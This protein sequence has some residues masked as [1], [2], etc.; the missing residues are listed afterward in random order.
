MHPICLQTIMPTVS[1]YLSVEKRGRTGRSRR[2]PSASSPWA[3]K[4]KTCRSG[5][6]CNR[7]ASSLQ[8]LFTEPDWSKACCERTFI[9]L[10][11]RCDKPWSWASYRQWQTLTCLSGLRVEL[12]SWECSRWRR[13]GGVGSGE[14][15]Q[16]SRC[17][18]GPSWKNPFRMRRVLGTSKPHTNLDK[19]K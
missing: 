18:L 12:W 15:W 7:K 16:R 2:S 8:S 4:F 5:L 10:C 17:I 6:S 1:T 3:S 11:S 9:Q 14:G 19:W 13:K